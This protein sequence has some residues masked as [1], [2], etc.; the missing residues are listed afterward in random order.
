MEFSSVIQKHQNIRS[1][2]LE[3]M[4]VLDE[5]TFSGRR[6][7][8]LPPSVSTSGKSSLSIPNGVAKAA[9]APLVDLLD[10]SSDDTP[11]PTSSGDNFLQDLLGVDIT[12]PSAQPG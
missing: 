8:S 12:Q 9:A 4:P 2:L 6:A 5:A 1:T 10:L 3:R 11:A 7:G